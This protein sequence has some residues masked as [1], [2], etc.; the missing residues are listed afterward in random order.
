VTS[1]RS[2]IHLE[3]GTHNPFAPPFDFL[4]RVFLPLLREM[5]VNVQAEL[6]RPGFYPAGGGRFKV[7][8]DPSR[9]LSEVDL[10]ERGEVHRFIAVARVSN[11]PRRIAERELA[12]LEN[13]LDLNRDWLEL[14]EVHNAAGPGN[15]VLVEIDSEHATELFT[16]FGQRGKRAEQVAGELASE[17]LHYLGSG[18]PVGPYLADQL[19]IPMAL[20]GRGSF[21]TTTPTSHCLTNIAVIRAFLDT[22]VDVRDEPNGTSRITVGTV[23]QE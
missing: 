18:V 21:R 23:E 5:G 14:E 4:D 9:Q 11:L 7:V 2:E 16:G 22:P 3:G 15:V 8:I 13:K 10:L 19:L 12:T 6:E 17:V 20:A 1:G